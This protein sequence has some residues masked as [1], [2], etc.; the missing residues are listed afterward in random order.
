[1]V[2]T[3]KQFQRRY[4]NVLDIFLAKPKFPLVAGRRMHKKV[5]WCGSQECLA[6]RMSDF[7]KKAVIPIKVAERSTVDCA[8]VRK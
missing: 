1:M 6:C 4:V 2:L 8:R 5:Y 3:V 7:L